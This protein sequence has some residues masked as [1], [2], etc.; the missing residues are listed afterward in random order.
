MGDSCRSHISKI[1]RKHKSSII[2][3][4]LS[5]INQGIKFRC[6]DTAYMKISCRLSSRHKML[7]NE[8][9]NMDLWKVKDMPGYNWNLPHNEF[10]RIP[11]FS[12][13]SF[14]RWPNTL[15]QLT[16]RRCHEED[17]AAGHTPGRKRRGVGLDTALC[18]AFCPLASDS[19][20]KS[21]FTQK[22]I[23]SPF[24]CKTNSINTNTV[25]E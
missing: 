21:F 18:S 23:I 17:P 11:A 5:Q 20:K 7:K 12:I 24:T 14:K 9:I 19:F 10:V 22:I 4:N 6:N 2:Q 3:H 25:L 8:I 16:L 1:Q 15:C 13:E